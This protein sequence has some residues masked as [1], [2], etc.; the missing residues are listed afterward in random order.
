VISLLL[1]FALA[2]ATLAFA[3]AQATG[4]PPVTVARGESS[5]VDE[6]KQT[7]ART[8]AEWEALWKAHAGAQPA[9]KV[10]LSQRLVVAV[11][12]GTRPTAGYTVEVRAT[13]VEGGA[14]VVEYVEQRPDP[15]DIT[16]QVITSPF[17]IVTVPRHEGPVRFDRRIGK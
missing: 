13:R 16:A 11:F 12:L 10:D 3:L 15:G 14:L 2:Q 5:A 7:V 1:A 4:G 6:L 9:P 8:S 17:H